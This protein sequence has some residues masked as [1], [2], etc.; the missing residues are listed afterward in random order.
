MARPVARGSGD[1]R[2]EGTLTLEGKS[3]VV[4]GTVEGFTREEAEAA[5]LLEGR[6][7]AGQRLGEDVRRGAR[8]RSRRGQAHKAEELGIPVIDGSAFRGTARVGGAPRTLTRRVVGRTRRAANGAEERGVA[9]VPG[10]STVSGGDVCTLGQGG[11]TVPE[12]PSPL[13]TR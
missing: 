12:G 4:T 7:V 3:V 11:G 8:E 2:L 6:E 5:I 10:V 1:E 9:N 13:V